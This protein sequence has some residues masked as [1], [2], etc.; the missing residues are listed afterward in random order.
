MLDIV[1]IMKVRNRE[2]FIQFEKEAFRIM[3]THG[4][5]LLSAFVPDPGLSSTSDFDEVHYLRFP[6]QQAFSAY[7]ADPALTGMADL[8]SQAISDTEIYVS[9]KKLSY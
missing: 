1:V 8:R 4:G 7:R 5:E 9:G 3:G 2:L 6:S